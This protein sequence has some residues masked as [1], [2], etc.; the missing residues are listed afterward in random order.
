MDAERCTKEEAAARP[1]SFQGAYARFFKRP[2]DFFLAALAVGAFSPL[3]LAIA[4]LVAARLGRPVLFRQKRPG[5]N[6]RIFTLYKFRT[7]TEGCGKDGKRLPDGERLTRFGKTLRETSLDELPGLFNILKGEMSIVGPR[8]QLVED[9]VFMTDE[10]RRRHSV[11]PGLSGLAQASGRNCILWEDKLQYDLAYLNHISF[12][13]DLKI[14][15]R[16]IRTVLKKS[17][18]NAEGQDTSEDLGDYLL[19]TGAIDQAAYQRSKE[20]ARQYV[21]GEPI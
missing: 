10:Q 15:G 8:P 6:E 5:L 21:W 19:R 1:P 9:L 16:T 18:V 13:G 3:L 4:L 2:M 7:M 20:K 12:R 11:L 14:I 17:G